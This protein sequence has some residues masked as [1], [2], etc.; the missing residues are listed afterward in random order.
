MAIVLENYKWS[1]YYYTSL[2]LSDL[3]P[4]KISIPDQWGLMISPAIQSHQNTLI[5]IKG[6]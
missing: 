2:G 3:Y 5:K 1:D 4:E 6:T